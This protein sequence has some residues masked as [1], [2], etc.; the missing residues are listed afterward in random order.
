MIG[1]FLFHKFTY[2]NTAGFGFGANGNAFGV[3]GM[4]PI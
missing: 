2:K 3:N 1:D 4:K